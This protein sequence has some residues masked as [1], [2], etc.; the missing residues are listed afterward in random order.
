[1]SQDWIASTAG[2]LVLGLARDNR[3]AWLWTQ[4]WDE[5]VWQNQAARWF[6]AK[7]KNGELTIRGPARPIK[8]QIK[9]LHRLGFEGVTTLARVQMT[10]DGHPVSQTCR[11]TPLRL[12]DGT[13]TVLCVSA[14]PVETGT[15]GP[16]PLE[17]R[18]LPHLGAYLL[19]D[20]DG[21]VYSGSD[22][23]LDLLAAG[24]LAD[25][26]RFKTTQLD[27]GLNLIEF[28]AGSAEAVDAEPVPAE[29][30]ETEEPVSE[31][32]GAFEDTPAEGE[33]P[34]EEAESGTAEPG[35][36]TG[37]ADED[38]PPDGRLAGLMAQFDQDSSLYEPLG[39]ED[40]VLPDELKVQPEEV[41]ATEQPGEPT[42]ETEELEADEPFGPDDSYADPGELEQ[43]AALDAPGTDEPQVETPDAPDDEPEPSDEPAPWIE[44]D[45]DEAEPAG[46]DEAL[47][48]PRLWR[49]TGRGFVPDSGAQDSDPGGIAALTGTPVEESDAEQSGTSSGEEVTDQAARYNFD[50]LA[51]ILT[52]KV[53]SEPEPAEPVTPVARDEGRNRPLSLSDEHLILNRLPLG[54]LIFRDQDVVFANRAMADLLGCASIAEL[55]ER[56]LD[57]IFPRMDDP[58]VNPGPVATLMDSQGGQVPVAA[59]LQSISW[60]GGP[61]LMLSAR[62]EDPSLSGEAAVRNFVEA[63]ASSLGG[64]FIELSRAG[65]IEAISGRSSELLQRRPELAMGRPLALFLATEDVPTF[66]EFLEKP[67]KRAGVSRPSQRVK[68]SNGA[69]VTLFTEGSAGIVTGY[70]GLIEAE[71]SQSGAE[72][73][74]PSRDD[75]EIDPALMAR[76]SRGVR[77]PL[78]TIIGFSQLMET[79]AFGPLGN[80]RYLEYARD[81]QSAGRD[82]EGLVDELDQYHRIQRGQ[83]MVETSDFALDDLLEECETVVRQQAGRRQVFVRSAISERLPLVTADRATMR[84]A[85][86]N[87]L[88]SAIDQTPQG[89]KVILSAQSEDSGAIGVHIRDSSSGTG[90]LAEKFAVF[91]EASG[92]KAEA[93]VPLK[94]SIGLALTRSLLAINSCTLAVHPSSGTGTL[95]S[96]TIPA[97]LVQ[98]PPEDQG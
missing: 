59:R 28:H 78:N 36:E 5:P 54:I 74:G 25:E 67:A 6:G 23:G 18:L 56:G 77:R 29:V 17:D 11:C 80:P 21:Q 65:V 63:L 61:A 41:P 64:G 12:A 73:T 30:A 84:Q 45:L 15:Q 27:G 69:R 49:V 16:E 44:P 24:A 8:G 82:I 70:F 79:E 42:L 10:I 33:L 96:L 89:G 9:R 48:A 97:E 86:L 4:D 68:A 93:M 50:E 52:E 83:Y 90:E 31:D 14:D 3:P 43:L 71:D 46:E 13:E 75:E 91:R 34:P 7:R 62:R 40:D 37:E 92:G 26:S 66:K 2:K 53:S 81:I 98:R 39:P 72:G 76:L 38:L 32:A 51:R 87:L 35:E 1:M 19:A 47:E 58:A 22:G 85:I 60:H 57:S 88:A 94:S 95:M 55:R 20:A